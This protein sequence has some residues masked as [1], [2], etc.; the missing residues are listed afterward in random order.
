MKNF[1][2][3][4]SA[5]LAF[6]VAGI[7]AGCASNSDHVVQHTRLGNDFEVV[8]TSTKRTLNPKEMAVLRAKVAEY[9]EKVGATSSG[10][11]YVKVFLKADQEGMPAEWV[12]VRF[13]RDSDLRFQLLGSDDSYY[14]GT[15]ASASY[16]YY[17]Y[18]YDDFSR[19][20]FQ[21]YDD[22]YYYGSRYY[23]PPDR[24]NNQDRNRNHDGDHDRGKD[25]DHEGDRNRDKDHPRPSDHPRNTPPSG[26]TPQVTRTRWE[27]DTPGQNNPPHENGFSRQAGASARSQHPDHSNERTY[28][29][30]IRT[31]SQ[32][33]PR[34]E[35]SSSQSAPSQPSIR[36]SSQTAPSYSPP[37]ARSESRQSS[38]P[39]TGP[40]ESS[41][42]G[43]SYQKQE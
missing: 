29:P 28:T 32:A 43:N 26:G 14:A 24:R 7:L 11:Y 37:A 34:T 4:G 35:S 27:G 15:R 39:D 36:T 42:A 20:S 30:P 9:L 40:K 8:E 38:N 3:L 16:D 17:P 21:Y 12:V 22:P 2:R 41:R 13:S 31:S 18:G 10:N 23:L 6:G 19:I 33:A 5:A 1:F 25:R